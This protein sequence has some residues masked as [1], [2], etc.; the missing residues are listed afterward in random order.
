VWNQKQRPDPPNRLAK[1]KYE[2][3]RQEGW[4]VEGMPRGSRRGAEILYLLLA[5]LNGRF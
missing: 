5:E 1:N 4:S 2:I 3:A